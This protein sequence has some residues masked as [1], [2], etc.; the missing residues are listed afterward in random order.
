VPRWGMVRMAGG[1]Q[2]G[3]DKKLGVIW[4]FTSIS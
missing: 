2:V 4:S 3:G 1:C